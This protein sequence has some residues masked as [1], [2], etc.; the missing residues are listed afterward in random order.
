MMK[1]IR[2]NL[3]DGAKPEVIPN[4]DTKIDY[5]TDNIFE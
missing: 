4:I 5:F 1:E 3:I 2:P